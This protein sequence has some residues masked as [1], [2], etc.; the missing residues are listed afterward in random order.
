[1]AAR[2][3]C[4]ACGSS[5]RLAVYAVPFHE[6]AIS[7][8]LAS[9]YPAIQPWLGQLEEYD[10][11][12]LKCASCSMFFQEFV[13]TE[14]FLEVIYNDWLGDSGARPADQAVADSLVEPAA[15][16]AGQEVYCISHYLNKPPQALR[17]LD[18]GMGMG[19]WARVAAH[20]GCV[21]YGFDL[22]SKRMDIAKRHNIRTVQE[23][24][25]TGLD[26]DFV[27][28]EQVL[29]HLSDPFERISRI[30]PALRQGGILKVSVPQAADL[31]SRLVDPDWYA[32]KGSPSSLNPIH[33][34]EHINCFTPRALDRLTERVDLRSVA[35]P[36]TSY[37]EFLRH[38]GLGSKTRMRHARAMVKGLARPLYDLIGRNNLYR[39]FIKV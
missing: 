33:P 19:L 30:A 28:T 16:R 35:I 12:V 9:Y 13:P 21:T 24:D 10:F 27:N 20:M 18:Y 8:F 5:E 26:L 17:V 29:E 31:A 6:P 2:E 23:D 1:M 11:S 39:W 4:P 36:V 34:L 15:S 25:F 38:A 32:P 7:S 3:H 22:S 37:W 14:R